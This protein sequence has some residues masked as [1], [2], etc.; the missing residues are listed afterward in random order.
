M[1]PEGI[2]SS[3]PSAVPSD[4]IPL[5]RSTGDV[6]P[7]V[8]LVSDVPAEVTANHV[9]SGDFEPTISTL[10]GGVE[11]I[12]IERAL[13]EIDRWEQKLEELGDS[14]LVPIAEDLRQFRA[15]LTADTLDVTAIGLAV[16][17]AGRTGSQCILKQP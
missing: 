15:L 11:N 2:E 5:E 7:T 8:S 1:P 17:R 3:S 4:E 10:R 16:G 6:G 14:Q 12:A 13:S 9:A